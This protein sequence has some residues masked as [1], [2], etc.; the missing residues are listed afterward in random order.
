MRECGDCNMCCK[1]PSVKNL[2]KDYEWCKHCEIGVGCK[3]YEE[4]P[5]QCKDFYC[6]WKMNFLDSFL[7]WDE[8]RTKKSGQLIPDIYVYL[9]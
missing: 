8:T 2:K 9:F 3:I 4:R 1:L 7:F 6:L 5:K